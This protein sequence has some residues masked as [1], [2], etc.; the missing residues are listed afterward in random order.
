MSQIPTSVPA[1]DKAFAI[2]DYVTES[3]RPVSAAQIAKD[4]GLPKSSMHN[5]LNTLLQKGVLR[6]D[7]NNLFFLGSYLLYWA[8]KFEQQQEVIALF[9]ELILSEPML[10][11]NTITLSTLDHAKGEVVYL[12]CHES[13]LP[14]G[15]TFRAGVRVPAAFSA[16][17]KAMMSTLPFEDV[18]A[19]YADGLPIPFTPNS[20]QSFEVLAGEFEQVKQTHT[21]LDNGQLR[22]GMYCLGTYIRN[23]HGKAVAGLAA[24]FPYHEYEQ[25]KE[26]VSVSLIALASKIENRLGFVE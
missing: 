9:Y 10:A 6:R 5:L 21:S 16:T 14:L 24:S 7:E 19:M 3:P 11:L 8:G 23:V 17:G 4:L 22:M 25:K 2:L 26:E 15:F 1:L 12:A 18:R 13:P 20:V